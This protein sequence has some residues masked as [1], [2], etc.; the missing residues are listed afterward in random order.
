[1]S[2]QAVA[3]RYAGAL[4]DVAHKN[5]TLDRAERQLGAFGQL[6]DQH[7]ELRR[8]LET[9]AVS[10]QK[11]RAIVD[12]VVEKAGDID[13]EVRQLVRMLA[14]RDRLGL[15]DNIAAAFQARLRQ[16]RQILQAEVITAVPLPDVQRA[17]LADALKRAAGS[18]LTITERIDPSIIGGVVAR[19]G[20]LVFDGSVT[21]QLE[22]M[23]QRL[24][25]EA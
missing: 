13:T 19:V 5:G 24:L 14:D 21:R 4:F 25:E 2:L 16:A 6:L 22:R 15:L 3:R 9:P 17:T 20:S 10:P 12:A 18:N 1:M 8:V 23:K 7:A 11:K